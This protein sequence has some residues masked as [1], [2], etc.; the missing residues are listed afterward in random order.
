MH[1]RVGGCRFAGLQQGHAQRLAEGVDRGTGQADQGQVVFD[2]GMDQ[3]AHV[4]SLV[5]RG[6]GGRP[7][8]NQASCMSKQTRL[9]AR[10]KLAWAGR[11]ASSQ[12]MK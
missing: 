12:S 11:G 5:L 6:R 8:Q 9:P 1:G 10:S 7:V 4:G 2:T 3:G